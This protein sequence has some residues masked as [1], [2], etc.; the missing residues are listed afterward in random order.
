[1][2]ALR[3]KWP[4]VR[5]PP[6]SRRGVTGAPEPP[7][8]PGPSVGNP[9]PCHRRT[10]ADRFTR[11]RGRRAD[12]RGPARRTAVRPATGALRLCGLVQDRPDPC[13][14]ARRRPPAAGAP[15]PRRAFLARHDRF[16]SRRAALA[17]LL[18]AARRG[19]LPS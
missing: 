9:Q 5:E 10:P 3:P 15:A 17:C 8:G 4:A 13:P 6:P 19:A 12:C 14:P 11:Y 16:Q 2:T 7:G 18:L 1:A